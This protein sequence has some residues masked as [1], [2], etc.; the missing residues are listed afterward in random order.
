DLDTDL[1]SL[2]RL[3]MQNQSQDHGSIIHECRSWLQLE[4]RFRVWVGSGSSFGVG[5]EV[6]VESGS[7]N[8]KWVQ[9]RSAGQ[10]LGQ[11]KDLDHQS[12]VSM[13]FV[14]S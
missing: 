13:S 4:S 5:F 7:E 2:F 3:V 1:L 11:I 8:L 14:E 6:W 9:V 12:E 10:D